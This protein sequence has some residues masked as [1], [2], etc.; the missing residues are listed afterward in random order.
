MAFNQLK[1]VFSAANQLLRRK[2]A[3]AKINREIV[4]EM[5]LVDSAI[6]DIEIKDNKK[7]TVIIK[8]DDIGDFLIWQYVIPEIEKQ[9]IRP[10]TFIGN[11]LVKP[12]I[13]NWFDFA[14]QY[15]WIDKSKLKDENYKTDLYKKIRALNSEVA[16][17]PMFTRNYLV[18]DMLIY[19]TAAN[20][21]IAWSRHL[22]TYYPNAN[23]IDQ[24]TTREIESDIK[25]Q[26]E[27]LRNFEF[28]SKVYNSQPD[29]TYKATFPSFGKQNRLVIVPVA[30]TKSRYWPVENFIQLIKEVL[31]KFDQILLLGGPNAIERC[32]LI[33]KGVNSPKLL[34]MSG[35]TSITEVVA[36]VGESKLML[37]PDTFSV[38]VA[39]MTAT[40]VVVISNG[41]NWQRFLNYAPYV[42]SKVEIVFHPG[43]KPDINKVKTLYSSA[44]IKSISVSAVKERL[45]KVIESSGKG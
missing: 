29:S 22:H 27:Y 10:I 18:D 23:A 12:L 21:R 14:D 26:L 31:E 45:L 5:A 35:K 6:K 11:Q 33:E 13:E 36:F 32:D 15:I 34:N 17:E 30:N 39:T 7:G 38:H 8:C 24:V 9:A 44:E 37:C 20:E 4:K 3:A 25:V 41:N 1:F 28:I 16:I 19:A 43:F 2:L 40:D 42:K